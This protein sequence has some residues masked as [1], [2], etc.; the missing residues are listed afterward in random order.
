MPDGPLGL[1]VIGYIPFMGR[2]P[3]LT[4]VRLTRR[5]G[6]IFS[7]RL[8]TKLVVVLNGRKAI[9]EAF[10]TK[11]QAFAGRPDW[12]LNRVNQGKGKLFCFDLTQPIAY[13]YKLLTNQVL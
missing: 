12:V 4:F 7:V 11:G 6:S 8:G 1:P 5:Y 3:Y 9:R 13:W 2:K 10:V